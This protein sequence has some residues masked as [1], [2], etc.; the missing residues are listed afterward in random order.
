MHLL[1]RDPGSEGVVIGLMSLRLC[2]VAEGHAVPLREL[3]V[4]VAYA[5]FLSANV[6]ISTMPLDLALVKYLSPL[7]SDL[8]GGRAEGCASGV[9]KTCH[10]LEKRRVP[11]QFTS[12]YSAQT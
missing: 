11:A 10:L 7:N 3:I 1:V 12:S 5:R 4:H 9:R 8:D 2:S 6:S